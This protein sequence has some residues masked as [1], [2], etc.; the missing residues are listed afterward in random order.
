L[1]RAPQGK[2][3]VV[4]SG[5]DGGFVTPTTSVNSADLLVDVVTS[6]KAQHKPGARWLMSRLTA[7]LAQTL[8]DSF[9][10]RVWTNS[11]V[12]GTP[13][14][15]LGFP[16]EISEDTPDRA[17]DSLSILFGD[18]HA[19]YTS[20]VGSANASCPIRTRPSRSRACTRGSARA[21][22]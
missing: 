8:K 14:T 13:S 15:L 22:A 6:L 3:Q 2:L 17:A 7:G 20:S 18:F 1:A 9:G 21:A 4:D 16:V 5:E 10:R 12:A 11:L 19:A